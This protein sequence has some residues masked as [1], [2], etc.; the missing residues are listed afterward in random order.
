MHVLVTGASSGIGEAIAR[1]FAGRRND[2]TLVARRGTELARVAAGCGGRTHLAQHDLMDVDGLEAIVHSAEEAL[3]PIDV[4]VNNAGAQ[5]VKQ[6]ANVDRR[7][8]DV[9]L[10]V[11]LLAPIR[12]THAVL[13]GMLERGHGTIVNVASVAAFAHVPGQTHYSATKAGLAAFS[14]S[15]GLEVRPRGVQVLTVFPGPVRT[16]MGE[17]AFAAYAD[18]PPGPIPWGTPDELARRVVAAVGRRSEVLVYPRFYL[19]AR[20]WP[21]IARMVIRRLAPH[22]RA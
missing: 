15:L 18:A 17:G 13:P 14:V 2:L 16:P 10:T 21:G 12:L 7:E 6:V 5:T 4:L 22:P 20:W 11:N 1:T 8:R 19:L 3:G 9:M